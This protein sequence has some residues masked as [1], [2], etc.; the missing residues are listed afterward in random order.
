M[1]VE[2]LASRF[3]KSRIPMMPTVKHMGVFK[4]TDGTSTETISWIFEQLHQLQ[5]KI[6]G[7]TEI[8]HG[9]YRSTEGMNQG[10]THGFIMTF[11][12][13]GARDR[14]LEHPEHIRLRDVVLPCLQ[15]VVVFDFVADGQS[16]STKGPAQ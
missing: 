11:E 1:A 14:Y 7:I 13:E 4:F 5:D 15:S 2:I 10:F 3:E 16:F 12:N 6:P 8:I 9:P